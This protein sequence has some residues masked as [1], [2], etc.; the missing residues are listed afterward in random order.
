MYFESLP[1]REY[2]G[3]LVT[4]ITVSIKRR[5][6][7]PESKNL[8]DTMII[9]DGSTPEIVAHEYYGHVKWWWVVCLVNLLTEPGDWPM[10][11]SEL[12]DWISRTHGDSSRDIAHYL[13]DGVPSPRQFRVEFRDG[14]GN[15]IRHH[16]RGEGLGAERN[17]MIVARGTPTTYEE[18]ARE[19]NDAKRRIR[20]LKREHLD[21]FVLEYKREMGTRSVEGIVV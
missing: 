5:A 21:S 9:P 20:L 14:D 12:D 10:S 4:D 8:F 18:V 6:G 13:R 19:E 3:R 7:V 1:K 17:G 11:E 16:E 2:A 15:T